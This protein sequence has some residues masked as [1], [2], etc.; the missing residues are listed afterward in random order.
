MSMLVSETGD[1]KMPASWQIEFEEMNPV[2]VAY[3]QQ[4]KLSD[5]PELVLDHLESVETEFWVDTFA[6]SQPGGDVVSWEDKRQ[7]LEAIMERTDD[8]IEFG[9]EIRY[10]DS[11]NMLHYLRGLIFKTI[12]LIP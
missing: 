8:I 5:H 6:E 11:I 4:E 10:P 1:L 9:D 2:V 12:Q 7:T 3:C